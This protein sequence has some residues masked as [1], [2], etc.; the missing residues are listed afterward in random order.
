M[1]D[2]TQVGVMPPGQICPA[3]TIIE[4]PSPTRRSRHSREGGNPVSMPHDLLYYLDSR[5]RGN[6]GRG[7]ILL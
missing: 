7:I 5:L 4:T 2:S 1:L 3:A 6:D